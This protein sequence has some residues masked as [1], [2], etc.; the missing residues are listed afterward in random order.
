MFFGTL[1]RPRGARRPGRHRLRQQRQRRAC[2]YGQPAAAGETFR[3]ERPALRRGARRFG[4]DLHGH[5]SGRAGTEGTAGAAHHPHASGRRGGREAGLPARRHERE[6]RSLSPAALRCAQRHD[7]AGA[8]RQAH[9]GGRRAD[10]A[11]GLHAR[12]YARQRVRHPRRGA[13]HHLVADQDVPH[14]HGPQR[15]FHRHGRRYAD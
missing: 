2:P 5:R 13:E 11:A 14:A 8:A 1:R 7:S 4:Q 6:T 3:E 12:P 15:A 9:G 10:R